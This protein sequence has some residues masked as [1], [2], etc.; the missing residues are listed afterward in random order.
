MD[1]KKENNLNH[2]NIFKSHAHSNYFEAIASTGFLGF[3]FFILF[4]FIYF[5]I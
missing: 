2:L 3:F 1:F 4:C 5:F